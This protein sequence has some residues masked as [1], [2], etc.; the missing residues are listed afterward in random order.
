MDRLDATRILVTF[1]RLGSFAE[2]A[3]QMRQSPS[4]ATRYNARLEDQLGLMLLTRT[5]RSLRLTDCG[6]IL[7]ASGP[8]ILT[9]MGRGGLACSGEADL[10]H[11]VKGDQFVL[12]TLV[13]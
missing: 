12:A 6:E 2:A 13:S 3:P 8:Q 10:R 9:D 5:T 4:V 7:L 1:A 11:L